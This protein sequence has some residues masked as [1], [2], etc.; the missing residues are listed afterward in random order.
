MEWKLFIPRAKHGERPLETRVLAPCFDSN[1]KKTWKRPGN[2]GF[3]TA[4]FT[5]RRNDNPLVE[6][7][8][9]T[10]RFAL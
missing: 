7:R 5:V 9:L 6:T 3:D 2:R 8:V 1:D 10:P 4:F